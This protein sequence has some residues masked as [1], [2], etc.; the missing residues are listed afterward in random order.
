M[1]QEAEAIFACKLVH[2]LEASWKRAD[3]LE[4]LVN[5][6]VAYYLEHILVEVFE[7]HFSL[8]F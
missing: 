6:L 2:L 8:L 4:S 7:A 5:K 1:V 3:V